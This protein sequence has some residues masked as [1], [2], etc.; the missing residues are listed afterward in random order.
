M[1]EDM[2]VNPQRAKQLTENIAAITSRINAASKNGQKVAA[3]LHKQ[4]R[5]P[6]LPCT[7]PPHSRLEAEARKRHP[8]PAPAAQP[9]TDPFWRELCPRAPREVETAPA[10]D[11]MAHDRRSAV[12]QMQAAG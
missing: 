12:E 10:L 4:H 9:A 1:A 6:S 11:P 7:G 5:F 8:R 3:A 2:H